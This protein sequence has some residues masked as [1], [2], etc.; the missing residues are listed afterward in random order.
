[1]REETPY[2]SLG[3]DVVDDVRNENHTKTEGAHEPSQH[4]VV[5]ELIGEGFES[6][7]GAQG[8]ASARDGRTKSMTQALEVRAHAVLVGDQACRR[9]GQPV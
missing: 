8:V 5:G 6:T 4:V 9:I 1:M 2:A 7:D 3:H